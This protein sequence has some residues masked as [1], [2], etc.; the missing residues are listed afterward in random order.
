MK[1]I[2]K[3]GF[4]ALA[5]SPALALAASDPTLSNVQTLVQ[6]I[7]NII[8]ILIPIVIALALLYF[9]Y[10]LARFILAAG[11]EDARKNGRQIMIWGVV[12]LFVII[13]VW[14]LVRF[15]IGALGLDV[16]SP[17][18]VPTVPGI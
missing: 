18:T 7:G 11:D 10:G 1:Y 12:A 3:I 5:W 4:G 13:A 2:K 8:S 9:F 17:A 15:L 16:A 6:S 14:G